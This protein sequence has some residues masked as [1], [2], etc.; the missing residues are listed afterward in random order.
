MWLVLEYNSCSSIAHPLL[1]PSE[2]AAR[3]EVNSILSEWEES[4]RGASGPQNSYESD[5]GLI[6]RWRPA[7]SDT[8]V[9][10]YKIS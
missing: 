10:L 4:E 9:E 1:F 2:H 6:A 8:T 5:W 3:G 7:G